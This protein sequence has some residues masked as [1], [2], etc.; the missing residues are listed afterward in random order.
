MTTNHTSHLTLYIMGAI[1]LAVGLAFLRTL[2]RITLPS[3]KRA[4]PQNTG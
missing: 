1:V 3:A 4:K 2:T